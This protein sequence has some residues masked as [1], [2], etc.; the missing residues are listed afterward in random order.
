MAASKFAGKKTATKAKP[1]VSALA[2]AAA[3]AKAGGDRDPFFDIPEGESRASFVCTFLGI[4]EKELVAGRDPYVAA[5]FHNDEI[6]ER[7]ALYCVSSKALSATG[8]RV[9]AL[10]MAVRGLTDEDEYN[11]WDPSGSFVDAIQGIDNG[12]CPPDDTTTYAEYAAALV[13]SVQVEVIAVRGST[14][15]DG[16]YYRNCTYKAVEAEG[17]AAE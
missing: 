2:Q 15:D 10:A 17:Q 14:R 9:K 4:E 13:G 7:V 5:K 8:P 12:D 1:R 3:S 11:A 16:D 6:G